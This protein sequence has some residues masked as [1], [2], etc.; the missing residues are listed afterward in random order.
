MTDE[1]TPVM[2]TDETPAAAE[3]QR[4]TKRADSETY[5]ATYVQKLKDEAIGRRKENKELKSQLD[6]LTAK[7]SAFDSVLNKVTEMEQLIQQERTARKQAE[8]QSVRT[9]IAAQFGL[10]AE[11][12]ARLQ[13]DTPD[14]IRADA[15]LLSKALPKPTTLPR[16]SP[17]ASGTPDDNRDLVDKIH[18][19]LS[20]RPKPG[21]NPF[22]DPDF[23]RTKGGS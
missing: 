11:L 22:F 20:G 3:P 14:A 13:G 21:S 8:L 2:G 19:Q 17:G 23:H 7:L 5:D 1:Q 18:S 4:S 9:S 6:Q 10:P 12:A 15:E 16:M